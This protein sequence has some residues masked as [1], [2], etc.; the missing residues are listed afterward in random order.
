MHLFV[1]PDSVFPALEAEEEEK[2][3]KGRGRGKK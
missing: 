2:P 3:E 1:N